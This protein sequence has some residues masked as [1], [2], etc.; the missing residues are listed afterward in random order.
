MRF[1]AG[2]FFVFIISA[3][4][5]SLYLSQNNLPKEK[6]TSFGIANSNTVSVSS[7]VDIRVKRALNYG[8]IGSV[9]GGS[10]GTVPDVAPDETVIVEE[11]NSINEIEENNTIEED[12]TANESNYLF[13]ESKILA[14]WRSSMYGYQ[15][16]KPPSY[17][18]DVA[19]DISSKFPGTVPGGIWLVGETDGSGPGTLLYMKS[20]G[21]YPNIAFEK[22]DV[23]EEYLNAFDKANVKVI[24]QV[25]PMSADINT[26][27][28]IVMSQY[29]HHSSVIGFGVDIEWYGTCNDGCKPSAEDV[30]SWNDKLHSIN[31]NYT[32]MIKHFEESK[33]PTG[34]P[35][36]ILIVCD[37]EENGK[38]NTLVSEHALMESK[39]K[40]NP[41][42]AQYGY[43]SDK[44]I[45]QDMQDP[46]KQLGNAIEDRI[47]RPIS[48][49][50]VDFS[51][52][53]LYP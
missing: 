18:V 7:Y 34:I 46:I 17:W 39:F 44:N 6:I 26:L 38:L 51:I 28:D 11:G 9:S 45:W 15:Q 1:L 27:I 20:T 48:H 12:E 4:F 19:K 40:N 52:M 25:E 2:A 43:P 36:N 3:A 13:V 31:Q 24:L 32:L 8:S 14:G 22:G 16:Q 21:S 5:F 50:W 29:K 42:G 33:L 35:S 37:D 23:S 41:F 49:F 53:D 10:S 47:G 30:I